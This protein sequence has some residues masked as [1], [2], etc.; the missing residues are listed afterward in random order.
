[1]TAYDIFRRY[2]TGGKKAEELTEMIRRREAM[3]TGCG[4]RPVSSDGGGRGSRDASMRLLD[5]VGNIEELREKLRI[6]LERREQD[7]MC[8]LYLAELLPEVHGG[9]MVR[10]VL[11]GKSLKETGVAMGYSGSHVRRL[12]KEAD[13]MCRRIRIISWD[14]VHTPV[15]SMDD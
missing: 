6:C 9:V 13:D 3:A 14:R 4:V 10:M 5:Y 8:C 12:K 2:Q 15:I 1:M 11:E 7:R